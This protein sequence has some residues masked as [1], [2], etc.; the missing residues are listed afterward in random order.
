MVNP[1]P[2]TKMFSIKDVDQFAQGLKELMLR[3][4]RVERELA[5]VKK[6][7]KASPTPAR[8]TG[9]G[10]HTGR[11]RKPR[12]AEEAVLAVFEQA[13]KPKTKLT[14]RAV[15]KKLRVDVE[16][17]RPVVWRL[18]DAKKLRKFGSRTDASY[19]LRRA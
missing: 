5:K 13:K 1:M 19:E 15:A 12:I 18:R 11:G 10:V 8:A 3:L 9:N 16:R 2:D 17:L 4:S 7:P 14:V 6:A